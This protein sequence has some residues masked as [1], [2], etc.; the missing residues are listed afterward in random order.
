MRYILNLGLLFLFLA[1]KTTATVSSQE[2]QNATEIQ[3][4]V[5]VGKQNRS[6]LEQ[7]PF[8]K[9][10]NR[11]FEKYKVDTK[12]IE[13]IKPLLEG[14]KIKAFM[15]T[16]C[17][18]SKRETPTFYKILDTANFDYSNFELITVDR[19]KSTPDALEKDMNIIRVPTFIFYKEGKELGRYVEYPR[20][21]LE[22]DMLAI[23][24]QS[25][26]KHSYEN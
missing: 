9:W 8:R 19:S 24:S 22:K 15:G 18:D 11:N 25:G 4:G 26:Y 10:F 1:C 20:K 7:E 13:E 14:I 2:I 17:G 5:L 16:W 23:L 3:N 12:T 6:A 21:S